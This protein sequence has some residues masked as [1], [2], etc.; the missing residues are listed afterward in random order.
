MPTRFFPI[1]L[2]IETNR[3]H[4]LMFTG[5]NEEAK[6]LYLAH[7]GKVREPSDKLWEQVIAE[8]FAK[9]GKAGLTHPM[10]AEIEMELGV[11]A[12]AIAR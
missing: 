11:S 7:K 10:M 1:D 12:D 6:A 5:R 2:E 9:L 4:A 8:D 3:A